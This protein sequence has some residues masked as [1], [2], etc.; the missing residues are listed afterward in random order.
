[1]EGHLP[2]IIGASNMEKA[3]KGLGLAGDYVVQK[4]TIYANDGKPTS[5]QFI[6]SRSL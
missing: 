6:I 4:Q 3:L 5:E 2:K 1:M